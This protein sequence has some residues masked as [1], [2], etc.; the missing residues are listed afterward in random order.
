[1]HAHILEIRQ[2][3]QNMDDIRIQ[4]EAHLAKS[5]T[6]SKDFIVQSMENKLV[7][8]SK[9]VFAL[10]EEIAPKMPAGQPSPEG[11]G[12]RPGHFDQ[13]FACNFARNKG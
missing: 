4:S 13:P 6:E 2:E 5:I 9:Q 3:M 8:L 7:G 12:S 1:M 11:G 10:V